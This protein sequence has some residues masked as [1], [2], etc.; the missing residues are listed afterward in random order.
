M[1]YTIKALHYATQQV[2]GPQ[3][4][5]QTAWQERVEFYYY[6]FLVRG[7]GATAIVDC[8]TSTFAPVNEVLR[9]ELG[10]QG[11]ARPTRGEQAVTALLA[12]E[13]V[14]PQDVDVVAIT[15]FHWDHV[16]NVAL[17]PN[18]RFLVSEQGW[19]T[20]QDLR[21][22]V[23]AMV[24][25]PVFP[26][27]ALDFLAAQAERVDL[28]PDGLTPLPGVEIRH[29]GGHT[30]DSAAF[31]IPTGEGRVVIPGDTIWTYANLERNVPVGAAVSIRQCH[32]AMAWARSA[33][34][35]VLPTHDPAILG[36]Y[37]AGVGLG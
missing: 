23:P 13:G 29:V 5:F 10:D 25:D 6:V 28:T 2:P 37:P 12:E 27:Q 22:N 17:F 31:T 20:H 11:T 32:E 33:G 30:A 1:S 7:E 35:I 15:H 18:A 34:D 9:R 19:K 36:R 16:G 8:G 24:A 4:Y 14:V 21:A 26:D 3:A